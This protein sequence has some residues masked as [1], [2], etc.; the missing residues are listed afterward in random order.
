[1]PDQRNPPVSRTRQNSQFTV[2]LESVDR[3]KKQNSLPEMGA[4]IESDGNYYVGNGAEWVQFAP[5]DNNAL[6]IGWARYDDT[7]FTSEDPYLMTANTEFTLPNN[8]GV[9]NDPYVLGMY[10]SPSFDLQAGSTYAITISFKASMNNNNAHADLNFYCPTDADYENIADVIV[11]P[12]GNGVEHVYSRSFNFYANT[13]V[14]RD[15]LQIKFN[16]SHAGAIYGVIYFIEK[17]S[18]A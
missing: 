6:Q 15:G 12:K 16:A 2:Q 1:M 8:G 5:I 14:A 4:L 18:H 9:T 3:T 17:L 11:F 10:T 13:N 7:E